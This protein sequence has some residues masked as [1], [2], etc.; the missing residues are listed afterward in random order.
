MTAVTKKNAGTVVATFPQELARLYAKKNASVFLWD[1]ETKTYWR[2]LGGEMRVWR[3]MTQQDVFDAMSALIE[4]HGGGGAITQSRVTNAVKQLH[5]VTPRV[6]SVAVD[7]HVTL[8]DCQLDLSTLQPVPYDPLHMALTRVHC[9][10]ADIGRPAPMLEKYLDETCREENET[11]DPLHRLQLEEVLGWLLCNDPAETIVMLDGNSQNGKSPFMDVGRGLLGADRCHAASLTDL[12]T[13]G[14]NL[15]DL[16]GKKAN[17]R[18]EEESVTVNMARL[19]EIASGEPMTARRLYEQNT[20]FRW[21]G[22]MMFSSNN[23]P[24]MPGFDPAAKRRFMVV[25]FRH[26]TDMRKADRYLARKI[27]ASEIHGVLRLALEGIARLRDNNFQFTQSPASLAALDDLERANN[28]AVDFLLSCY[29]P[30]PD[31]R[32]PVSTMYGAYVTWCGNN[33]RKGVMSSHHFHRNCTRLLGET[34]VRSVGSVKMR[35]HDVSLAP[36][37]IEAEPP[38]QIPNLLPVL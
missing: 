35:C 4:E 3:P 19:K 1:D 18:A 32:V 10:W 37:E 2:N 21:P 20:T 26:R 38:E 14:F 33:G 27:V 23:P 12:T 31:G 9:S 13:Q 16:I 6:A 17:I 34:K 11:P 24:P 5:R 28:S 8:D 25:K 36:L 22:R 15:V 30:D 29:V 7:T